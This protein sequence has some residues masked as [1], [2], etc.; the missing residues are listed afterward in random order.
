MEFA[1]GG[2]LF[3]DEITELPF[4]TQ[5]KLLQVLQKRQFFKVGGTR[6]IKIDF[7]LV[8]ATKRNVTEVVKAGNFSEE[9]FYLLYAVP[10]EVPPLRERR[11]EI[12]PLLRYYLNYYNQKYDDCKSFSPR[13]LSFLRHHDWP[14]N[15]RE[16]KNTVER[17]AV[18]TVE[19]VI[20]YKYVLSALGNN[21]KISYINNE[22]TSFDLMEEFEQDL[23]TQCN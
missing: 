17:L 21:G 11:N 14:G 23:I 5:V 12:L 10:V 6:P 9:L 22:K 16:L 3:L 2:T 15:I 1:R 19:E 20:S 7:R 4:E 18:T 8:T 13:A